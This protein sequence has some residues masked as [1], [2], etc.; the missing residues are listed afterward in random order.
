MRCGILTGVVSAALVAWGACASAGGGPKKSD[1]GVRLVAD[2]T[3]QRVD[4]F[5][6]G[7]PFTSYLQPDPVYKPILYPLRTAK[8]T[9]ITRGFPLE[10]R[11]RERT[12]HPHQVGS[13]LNYGDV[14]E[15]DF[16]GHS[17][18]IPEA[19][20]AKMGTIRHR[21]IVRTTDGADGG[22]LDVE[23]D[24][25]RPNGRALLKEATRF[26]FRAGPDLRAIDRITTL[27]A[28]DQPVAFNPTKEGMF[29]VR[30]CRA[31]EH[32]ADKPEVFIDASGNPTT[33]PVLDNAGVTGLYVSSEG[34]TGDAVWGKRAR[35]VM[36]TG[37]VEGEDVALAIL[38]HPKN[39]G[40]PTYWHARGYGLFAAN[41]LGQKVFSEGKEDLNFALEPD[42]S[43][44]FR[45]RIVILSGKAD[46]PRME[47]QY[48]RFLAETP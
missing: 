33:V 8:G 19:E 32:P 47:E 40:H 1:A 44:T 20:R 11:A 18:A 21:R 2:P 43:A 39:P 3:G 31:L 42:E 36:L 15:I 30:V 28:V 46:A 23:M 25:N 34:L 24:W 41:P 13:W 7:K 17:D 37:T 16:W 4:V 6:D 22:E 38:D 9:V 12:D 27:T 35:W 45:Y 14:N 5:V 26:V 10:P 48:K 29:G